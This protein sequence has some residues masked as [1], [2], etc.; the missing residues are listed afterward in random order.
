MQ[1]KY[2]PTFEVNIPE[3]KMDYAVEVLREAEHNRGYLR[4]PLQIGKN[5][6]IICLGDAWGHSV[7]YRARK[8]AYELIKA[9]SNYGENKK[10]PTQFT[11]MVQKELLARFRKLE[12]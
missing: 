8:V 1:F 10:W 7:V 2:A 6:R 4:S 11:T 3:E 5:P 9:Y 12:A